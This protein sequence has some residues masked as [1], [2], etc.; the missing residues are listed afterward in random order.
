MSNVK[1]KSD[2]VDAVAAKSGLT[3]ADAGKAVDAVVSSV[4]EILKSG[5]ELNLIGFGKFSAVAKAEREARNPSTGAKI[6][7]AASTAPKFAAGK[8]LKAALNA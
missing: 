2:L 8:A 7:V 6:T 1:S 4:T 3:K 5:D